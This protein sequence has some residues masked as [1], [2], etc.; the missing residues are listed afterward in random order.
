MNAAVFESDRQ[1][2]LVLP[3]IF[4]KASSYAQPNDWKVSANDKNPLKI[5][6]PFPMIKPQRVLGIQGS[7]APY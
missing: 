2:I 3:G 1:D 6:I 7:S 5:R 4:A